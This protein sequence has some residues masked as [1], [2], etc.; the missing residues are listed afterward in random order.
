M[1][2]ERASE[3]LSISQHPDIV[4]L[5]EKYAQ[6]N[7]TVVAHSLEGLI[8]LAGIY[9]AI[10]PWVVGFNHTSTLV[11]SNL[12]VGLGVAVLALCFASAYERTHGLSWVVVL[13]GIWLIVSLWIVTGVTLDASVIWSNCVIGAVVALLGLGA[14]GMGMM[15]TRR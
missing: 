3:H 15:R 7:E 10:S 14:T 1:A 8:F 4:E 12:V 2:T 5:R 9:A 6:T 11:V 13:M